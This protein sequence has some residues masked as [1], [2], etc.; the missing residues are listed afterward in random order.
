MVQNVHKPK[1][2]QDNVAVNMEDAANKNA[3]D[4][5]DEP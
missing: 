1:V 2:K 4:H 3:N 5:S